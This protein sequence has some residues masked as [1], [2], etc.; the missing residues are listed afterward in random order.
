MYVPSFITPLKLTYKECSKFGYQ[1]IQPIS[2][3]RSCQVDSDM[4]KKTIN[5]NVFNLFM[6]DALF[7]NVNVTSVVTIKWVWLGYRDDEV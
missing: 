7:G 1:L 4:N 3:H 5:F 2:R 6:E